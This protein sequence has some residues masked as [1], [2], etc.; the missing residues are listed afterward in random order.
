M[1]P[2]ATSLTKSPTRPQLPLPPFTDSII[3]SL[4]NTLSTPTSSDPI[5]KPPKNIVKKPVK[6]RALKALP[7][8]KK[9][10]SK[11]PLMPPYPAQVE[12]PAVTTRSG[13]TVKRRVWE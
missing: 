2:L 8:A 13:R 12:A 11:A 10:V 5:R 4:S 9:P 3:L 7:K 6:T 1:A